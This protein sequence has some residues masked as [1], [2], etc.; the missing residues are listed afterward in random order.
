LGRAWS[1]VDKKGRCERSSEY[2]HKN[3]LAEPYSPKESAMQTIDDSELVRPKSKGLL[4]N[5]LDRAT[6]IEAKV[7]VACRSFRAV[8]NEVHCKHCKVQFW[9]ADNKAFKGYSQEVKH[10]V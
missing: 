9:A 2:L 7:C 1:G 5:S 10:L 3:R 6:L 8:E 4:S